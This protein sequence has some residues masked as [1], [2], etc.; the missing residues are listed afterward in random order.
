MDNLFSR[1]YGF[2]LSVGAEQELAR[3]C[4]GENLRGLREILTG[5]SAD[6]IGS[7]VEMLCI[8]SRWYEKAQAMEQGSG[9]E[10]RPLT[11]EELLLLPQWKFEALQSEALSAMLR[12]QGRTVE[13]EPPKK[14]K[15]PKSS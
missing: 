1:P 4:P 14:E 6:A 13:A 9:Y 2:L 12:D 11:A 7:S 8:L 10:P 3:L 5:R 15:A